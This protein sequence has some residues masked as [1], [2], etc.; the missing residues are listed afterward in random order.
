MI[1]EKRLWGNRY[2]ALA[3]HS[4]SMWAQPDVLGLFSGSVGSFLNNL[5]LS[6]M[7]FS[8]TVG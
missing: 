5:G 4:H 6:A 2:A 8:L 7:I 1:K 3:G